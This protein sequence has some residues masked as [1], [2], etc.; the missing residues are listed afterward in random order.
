MAPSSFLHCGRKR[1]SARR[2]LPTFAVRGAPSSESKILPAGT[3]GVYTTV[4][5]N[6]TQNKANPDADRVVPWGEQTWDEM[7]YGVIRYRNLVEDAQVAVA[8]GFD[9]A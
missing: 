9:G 1:S 6:S 4:F 8:T 3:K 2:S 5:D 7:V